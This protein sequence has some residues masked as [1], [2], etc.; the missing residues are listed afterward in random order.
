M[1][2]DHSRHIGVWSGW[3][4]FLDEITLPALMSLIQMTHVMFWSAAE[5]LNLSS[6]RKKPAQTYARISSGWSAITARVGA[7]QHFLRETIDSK[8]VRSMTL[9]VAI[10]CSQRRN[11]PSTGSDGDPCAATGV[12]P[13]T[14]DSTPSSSGV[15]TFSFFSWITMFHSGSNFFQPPA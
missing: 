11:L 1:A 2:S 10:S 9:P 7:C 14:F 15:M 8:S 4:L 13:D 3:Q 12:V 5:F 6:R